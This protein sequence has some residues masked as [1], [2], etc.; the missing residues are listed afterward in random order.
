MNHTTP[1]NLKLTLD[2]IR[3]IGPIIGPM[4]EAARSARQAAEVVRSMTPPC[5]PMDN[6]DLKNLLNPETSE[7]DLRDIF[8]DHLAKLILIELIAL[9]DD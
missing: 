6:D 7:D 8:R 1:P 2:A 9:L 5:L 3:Q 4:R